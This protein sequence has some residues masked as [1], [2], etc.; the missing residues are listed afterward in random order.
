M[1]NLLGPF[2]LRAN[3]PEIAEIAAPRRARG[4]SERPPELAELAELAELRDSRRAPISPRSRR[5]GEPIAPIMATRV[6]PVPH[7]TLRARCQRATHARIGRAASSRAGRAALLSYR[8]PGG[9][10]IPVLVQKIEVCRFP[11]YLHSVSLARRRVS[12]RRR[13]EGG[14]KSASVEE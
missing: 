1:W 11:L 2:L 4:P 14:E 3:S 12:A 9:P 5:L 10:N 8:Q 6:S 7:A 13:R